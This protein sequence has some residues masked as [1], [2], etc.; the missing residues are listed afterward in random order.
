MCVGGEA[1]KD[2]KVVETKWGGGG[3]TEEGEARGGGGEQTESESQRGRGLT[4]EV[5]FTC[6]SSPLCPQQLSPP[7]P[8]KFYLLPA[9]TLAV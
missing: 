6:F 2:Q 9:V 5:F 1:A 3:E 7:P 4:S 8:K